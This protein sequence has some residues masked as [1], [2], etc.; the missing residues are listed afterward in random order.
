VFQGTGIGAVP[1]DGA[2]APKYVGDMYQIYVFNR[3][4]AFIWY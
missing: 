2:Q 4:Y 3:Y 1:D